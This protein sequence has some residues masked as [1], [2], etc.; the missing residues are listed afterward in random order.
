[1]KKLRIW[2][3][4]LRWTLRKLSRRLQTLDPQ[5][6]AEAKKRLLRLMR[7]IRR[8][9]QLTVLLLRLL[10]LLRELIRVIL[11]SFQRSGRS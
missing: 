7:L 4:R 1:M 8:I 9:L 6:N 11:R 2:K 5:T 3:I 10:T